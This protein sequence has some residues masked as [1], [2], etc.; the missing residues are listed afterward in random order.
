MSSLTH[1]FKHHWRSFADQLRIEC[2]LTRLDWHLEGSLSGA[3]RKE[4]LAALKQELSTDPRPLLSTLGDLGSPRA[5]AAQYAD[6]STRLRPLW[7]IGIAIAAI[8]LVGYWIVF[9]AFSGGM[10]AA[11]LDGHP[12]PARASARFM[13]VEVEAFSSPDGF[14]IGWTSE[15]AWIA[16]PLVI[17]AIGFLLGARIWRLF[18]AVH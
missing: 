2:Y 1:S 10:L 17:I 12:T 3:D 9:L 7:S 6:G 15:W 16:V 18:T 14:G 4:V 5:L 11:I 8:A 13:F